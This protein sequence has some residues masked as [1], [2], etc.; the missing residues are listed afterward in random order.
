MKTIEVMVVVVV[1]V[2]VVEVNAMEWRLGLS[3]GAG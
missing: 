3:L 2:V 1:V